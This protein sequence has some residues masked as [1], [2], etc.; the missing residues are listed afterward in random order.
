VTWLAAGTAVHVRECSL[1]EPYDHSSKAPGLQPL[2]LK[3]EIPLV[4][5]GFAF[6]KCNLC[7]YVAEKG[8]IEKR[9]LRSSTAESGYREE[10]LEWGGTS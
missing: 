10:E 4:S 9:R 3:C 7:R 2:E 8:G 6:H 5:Q 1:P